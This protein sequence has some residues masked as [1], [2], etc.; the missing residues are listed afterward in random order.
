MPSLPTAELHRQVSP[1]TTP[2]TNAA[3]RTGRRQ[4]RFPRGNHH[5]RR[6]R[7][8]PH[9]P[10]APPS[11]AA[12][13]TPPPPAG[14]PASRADTRCP[15]T[16]KATAPPPVQRGAVQCGAVCGDVVR[17]GAATARSGVRRIWRG[18]EPV[19]C[20]RKS[21][22]NIMTRIACT[23]KIKTPRI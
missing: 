7:R 20:R 5:S 8:S 1:T 15:D 12:A 3:S 10:P 18:A 9:V 23:L 2:A 22:Q 16:P 11:F 14:P 17:C 13:T 4:R 21:V 19:Y 6:P